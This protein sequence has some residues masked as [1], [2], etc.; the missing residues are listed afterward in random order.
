MPYYYKVK[1]C[2]QRIRGGMMAKRYYPYDINAGKKLKSIKIDKI[3]AC[4]HKVIATDVPIKEVAKV[5][6]QIKN[7]YCAD[8]Y[9]KLKIKNALERYNP[10]YNEPL[11][12]QTKCGT[13]L[14]KCPVC[15]KLAHLTANGRM[16]ICFSCYSNGA[17]LTNDL[18]W[19]VYQNAEK[20][21]YM[22]VN[23]NTPFDD[24]Q[25]SNKIE[26]SKNLEDFDL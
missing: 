10:P 21:E 22:T 20:I 7:A 12:F 8:C 13:K 1:V 16:F 23:S 5:E 15:G 11:P 17:K 18:P 2:S 3:C 14:T 4:C 26:K 25:K 24:E 9:K 19:S 6:E